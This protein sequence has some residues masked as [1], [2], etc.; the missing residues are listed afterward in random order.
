MKQKSTAFILCLLGFLGIGGLHRFYLG[1]YVTGVLWLITGG[2]CGIGTIIDLL[3]LDNMVNVYNLMYT[4]MYGGRNTNSMNVA[5][6]NNYG[7][8]SEPQA[9]PLY[10][11][12]SN[13]TTEQPT[14]SQGGYQQQAYN[15]TPYPQKDPNDKTKM[16]IVGVLGGLLLLAIFV[17]IANLSSGTKEKSSNSISSLYDRS[18]DENNKLEGTTNITSAPYTF[19]FISKNQI[20]VLDRSGK[21]LPYNP[22]ASKTSVGD[23]VEEYRHLAAYGFYAFSLAEEFDEFPMEKLDRYARYVF[24]APLTSDSDID[25]PLV[26]SCINDAYRLE[27]SNGKMDQNFLL[28]KEGSSKAYN[29]ENRNGDL[30]YVYVEKGS[31]GGT[32]LRSEIVRNPFKRHSD[33]TQLS[34]SYS[35]SK[36]AYSV[37]VDAT[38]GVVE[39]AVEKGTN[40]LAVAEEVVGATS[41]VIAKADAA[42]ENASEAL[43]LFTDNERETI[44]SVVNEW[45]NC[46]NTYT[47]YNLNDIYADRLFY[48]SKTF[49]KDSAIKNKEKAINKF[50]DKYGL[51]SQNCSGI[52]MKRI[53]SQTIRCDFTK[54]VHLGNNVRDYHA[55][56]EMQEFGDKWRITRE[57]DTTTDYNI[58]KRRK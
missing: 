42:V 3:S 19:K 55:Y 13:P 50:V 17:G 8:P 33:E 21:S 20:E 43:P 28:D 26:K 30:H 12:N 7:Q 24:K 9:T 37:A 34:H 38:G 1:H 11:A 23:E 41:A 36:P 44:L 47:F 10:D 53:D 52:T 5:N 49:S 18:S 29:T 6:V 40:K 22:A 31:G 39:S 45:N 58:S 32:V 25:D 27:Q 54:T 46:H 56:L 57:S 15:Q 48:Y 2:L 51:Y 14:A 4:N 16:I 35:G